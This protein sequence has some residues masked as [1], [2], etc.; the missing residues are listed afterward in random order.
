MLFAISCSV[1]QQPLSPS[2]FEK[3]LMSME[4]SI[5]KGAWFSPDQLKGWMWALGS[6]YTILA[7][8]FLNDYSFSISAIWLNL[9]LLITRKQL[10]SQL[11]CQTEEAYL[12]NSVNFTPCR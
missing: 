8:I 5:L 10:T 7:L 2:M 4:K 12:Y 3:P 11:P 6:L 1:S 9:F